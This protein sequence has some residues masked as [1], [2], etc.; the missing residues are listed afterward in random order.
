MSQSKQQMQLHREALQ[1][2]SQQD[3]SNREYIQLVAGSITRISDFLNTFSQ[4]CSGRLANL[5][6]RLTGLE[7]KVIFLENKVGFDN[8]SDPNSN[9]DTRPESENEDPETDRC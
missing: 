4:S 3:W 7:R 5:D 1:R 6:S 8:P 9:P 2:R